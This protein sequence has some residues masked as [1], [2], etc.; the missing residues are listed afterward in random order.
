MLKEGII[1]IY[2]YIYSRNCEEHEAF[3]IH[4]EVKYINLVL[5]CK[6]YT[7]LCSSVTR[8]N[9]QYLVKQ[10]LREVPNLQI[11]DNFHP[12]LIQDVQVAS[13]KA[14]FYSKALYSV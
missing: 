12:S 13:G 14:E 4:N 11:F 3:V 6:K 1:D 8:Y 7:L 9:K 5:E 10:R 2:I